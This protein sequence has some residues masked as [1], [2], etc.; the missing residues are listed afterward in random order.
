MKESGNLLDVISSLVLIV[1]FVLSASCAPKRQV[2]SPQFVGEKLGYLQ[3]GRITRQEII[4]HLGNPSYLFEEGRIV[5][6]IWSDERTDS[7]AV[8][9]IVLIYSEGDVLAKH[10]VVRVR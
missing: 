7:M 3:D 6:Y 10:S 2:M 8:Y 5:V 1:I 4:N 9:N